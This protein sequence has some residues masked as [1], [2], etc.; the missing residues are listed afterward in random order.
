MTFK[1]LDEKVM[2]WAAEKGILRNGTIQGQFLK[3][4]EEA[5]EIFSTEDVCDAIGDTLVTLIILGRM[6]GI[7]VVE[8][9]ERAEERYEA[10]FI[11]LYGQ[12]AHAISRG[13]EFTQPLMSILGNV[14]S[15]ASYQ[16]L[17]PLE[18]LEKAYNEIAGRTGEMKDG[19]FVKDTFKQS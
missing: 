18:C 4:V 6:G 13:E 11:T 5:G 8:A 9:W 14:K 19:V 16:H 7:D 1:E 10:S 3:S 17:N 2:D 12:L 15:H